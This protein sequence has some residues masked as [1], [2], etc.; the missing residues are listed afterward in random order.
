MTLIQSTPELMYTEYISL[1]LSVVL[2]F[3]LK[4]LN[5]A[6]NGISHVITKYENQKIIIFA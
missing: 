4:H 6:I 3:T 5:A 1:P 2:L